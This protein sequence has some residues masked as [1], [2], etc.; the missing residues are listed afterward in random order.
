MGVKHG[1]SRSKKN[2]TYG[3]LITK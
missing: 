1:L 2:V 3:C